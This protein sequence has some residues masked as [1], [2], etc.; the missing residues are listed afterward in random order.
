LDVEFGHGLDL[1][2]AA[3]QLPLVVCSS[4]M[5]PMSRMMDC[6]LGKMPTTF[7]TMI[8][9]IGGPITQLLEA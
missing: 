2:V 6:S 8:Y 9:L 4:K 7:I 1:H 3:L 5:A